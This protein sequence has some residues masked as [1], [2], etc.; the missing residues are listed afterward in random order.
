VSL[1]NVTP[2]GAFAQMNAGAAIVL[3]HRFFGQSN[4][5]PQMNVQTL[6]VH[7]VAQAIEDLVYFAQND[8]LPM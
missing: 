3:E 2:Q 5:L 1:A 7:N 8:V 4:P 6:A